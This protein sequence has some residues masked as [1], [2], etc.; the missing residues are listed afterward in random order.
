MRAK[1][2]RPEVSI[3]SR[4]TTILSIR[5]DSD[6]YLSKTALLRE[7]LDSSFPG[8]VRT[9]Q[10]LE[11]TTMC[12]SSKTTLRDWKAL[13]GRSKRWVS[14]CGSARTQICEFFFVLFNKGQ[15]NVCPI[16]SYF[17]DCFSKLLP[18]TFVEAKVGSYHVT[19]HLTLRINFMRHF[20]I[21]CPAFPQP[22]YMI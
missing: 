13:R 5:P 18:L 9:P 19:F 8:T 22:Q 2:T 14:Q 3:P 10:G 21:V 4:W 12:S 1:T 20:L 17:A 6:P 11:T 15:H 16:S 7:A